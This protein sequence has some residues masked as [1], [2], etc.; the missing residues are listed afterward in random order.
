ML[1]IYENITPNEA[2]TLESCYD[3]PS[4]KISMIQ[5]FFCVYISFIQ[6]IFIYSSSL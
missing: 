1:H 4:G 6:I 5:L 3:C 2:V